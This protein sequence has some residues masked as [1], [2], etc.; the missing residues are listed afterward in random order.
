VDSRLGEEKTPEKECIGR[1]EKAKRECEPSRKR[2][3]GVM[4]GREKTGE[5][6][7]KLS[8]R[9]KKGKHQTPSKRNLKKKADG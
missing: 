4:S 2:P 6:S 3:W 5:I 1:T 9:G 8:V 7:P